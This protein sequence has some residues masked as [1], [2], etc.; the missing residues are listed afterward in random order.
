MARKRGIIVFATVLLAACSDVS[1]DGKTSATETPARQPNIIIIFAD[2]LGYAD[3]GIQGIREDVQT[4]HLDAL[5]NKGVRF[6]QAYI[7]APQC[8]P[9]RAA[10]LTGQYQSRLGLN[11]NKD[12]EVT[13]NIAT[14]HAQDTIAEDLKAQGYVTAMAGKWHIGKVNRIKD[15]GFDKIFYAHS[16]QQGRANMDETGGDRAF[17]PIEYNYHIDASANFA[18]SFIKRHADQPF[19]LYWAP[20]APHAPLDATDTYLDRFSTIEDPTRRQGLAIISA[21][22]DG[23]GQ[24]MERL[25]EN[26]LETNTL[27]FFM[28]DNGAPE[29]DPQKAIGSYNAPFRGEKGM[30]MEGGIRVPF[31]AA[32]PGQIPE[33]LIYDHPVMSLDIAATVRSLRQSDRPELMPGRNL[34]PFLQGIDKGAPHEALY[35]RW[36]SQA[37]IRKGPWKFIR[38]ANAEYLYNLAND[39]L[40]SENI[41]T[42]RPEE[43]KRLL[44]DLENWAQQAS[45]PGLNANPSG[46]KRTENL[47]TRYSYHMQ[48]A[49]RAKQ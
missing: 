37:A 2:D 23:V 25:Q 49:E 19:F 7:T 16:T 20:R 45:P 47:R 29:M 12:F 26:D 27:I 31:I 14:L 8:A 46:I 48:S 41:V 17:R 24:I 3:L 5:A 21:L 28:S 30:V 43:R 34:L 15:H 33:G 42:Q 38:F 40:E 36:E 35:W 10:L 4:P 11:T 18:S 9:S 1:R 13:K 44:D 39:P 32:W 22:D 6:T